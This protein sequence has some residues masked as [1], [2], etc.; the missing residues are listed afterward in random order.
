MFKIKHKHHRINLRL[1]AG[2]ILLLSA[3]IIYQQVRISKEKASIVDL[4]QI[5]KKGELRA[6]TLY[7]SASYFIY[8][9]KEMGYEYEICSR[10]ADS[11]GLKLKM[12]VAPNSKALVGMLERGEGDIVAYNL[13]KTIESK[14]KYL[15]CGRSFLTHQVL[16]QRNSDPS[17]MVHEVTELI[18]K[19]VVVHKGSRNLTRLQHLNS[20]IGG[21][22]HIK[23]ISVDSLSEEDL[24]GM[25][26]MGEID[27]TVID[28]NI[29]QFNKTFYKN[30]STS[31]SLSFSQHSSW[32]VRKT[33]KLLAARVDEWFRKNLQST[34]YKSTTKRY[35]ELSKGPSKYLT[36]GLVV[37]S[38]GSV[39]S[40]DKL[41]KIYA[42][43]IGWDWRLLASIA[44]QESN[45]DPLAENWTGAKGLMQ[46]MPKTAQTLGLPRDSLFDSQ[47]SIKGA[48][49][50][51]RIYE[52]NLSDIQ[53]K[54]QRIKLT[55]AAYNCGY[56]HIKD[57]RALARKHQQNPD[58]W[59]GENVG[60]YIFLKSRPEYYQD[61]VCEQGYLRGSETAQFVTEVWTRYEHYL[62]KGA[63]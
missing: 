34:E 22:I 20:E 16:V 26:A 45:F 50:L 36:T 15:Y 13:P 41:F 8:R 46:I 9:D 2:F 56:G 14:K 53:N 10:L 57:A 1:L 5:Q 40:F 62:K 30:I 44:Y 11:L 21:G 38:N 3:I 28:N 47:T 4:P 58:V 55:I 33:S 31:L 27:Y 48:A 60:K 37:L 12:V 23:A 25:V 24:I 32:M 6:L 52:R 17:K 61:P 54:E 7:S 51:L 19:T 18:G 49:K 39:S 59:D 42:K 43:K 35:F 29:A 63:R